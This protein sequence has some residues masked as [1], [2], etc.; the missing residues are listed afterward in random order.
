VS[1]KN[2]V[3]KPEASELA[4]LGAG[5][6]ALFAALTLVACESD[7]FKPNTAAGDKVPSSSNRM[8]A[9][10]ETWHDVCSMN[11]ADK[12]HHWNIADLLSEQKPFLV[13]FGTP[14]HCTMCV[15]QLVRVAT[16][17]EKYGD[18][19]AVLHVDGYKDDPTWVAWGIK[20]EPWTFIVDNEG[21][22]RKVFP[23]PTD[24]ILMEQ[25]IDQ[26]LEGRT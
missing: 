17:Q 16:L 21:V 20:G 26:V 1:Y 5:L 15:D 22:V 12:L 4:R 9:S 3:R 11:T 7:S 10:G 19:F 13:V 23:G 14:Q 25:V 8:I 2:R 18:R 6:V 24:V